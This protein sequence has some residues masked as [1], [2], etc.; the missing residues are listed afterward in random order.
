MAA[1]IPRFR[2][3]VKSPS[4]PSWSAAFAGRS[5]RRA[6]SIPAAIDGSWPWATGRRGSRLRCDAGAPDGTPPRRGRAPS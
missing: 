5:A 1:E 3:R 4:P 6:R 2:G